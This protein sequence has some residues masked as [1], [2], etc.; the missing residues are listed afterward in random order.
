VKNENSPDKWIVFDAKIK[1]RK[2]EIYL[3]DSFQSWRMTTISQADIH[4]GLDCDKGT[5]SEWQTSCYK[6]WQAEDDITCRHWK[7]TTEGEKEGAFGRPWLCKTKAGPVTMAWYIVPPPVKPHSAGH[8][9]ESIQSFID[10]QAL[11]DSAPLPL[12]SPLSRQQFVSLSQSFC[13]SPVELTDES[14]W[15]R[16]QI[17]RPQESLALYKSCN[18]LCHRLYRSNRQL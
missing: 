12:P 7:T 15:A 14:G 2:L 5:A 1:L 3:A 11:F 4:K 18:T 10:G 8:P 6:G 9:P 17:I 13:V 16:S